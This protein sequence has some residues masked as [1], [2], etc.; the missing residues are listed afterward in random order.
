MNENGKCSGADSADSAPVRRGFYVYALLDPLKGG[1]PF[2]I[3]KGRGLRYSDHYTTAYVGQ[4]SHKAYTIRRYRSLGL[5]DAHVFLATNLSE[6]EAFA[7]EIEEIAR[8][9]LRSDGGQLVNIALGGI[10]RRQPNTPRH[11]AAISRGSKGRVVSAETRAKLSA[12][13]KGRVPGPEHLAKISAALNGRPHTPEHIKAAAAARRGK[14]RILTEVER[15]RRRTPAAREA[16]AAANR[17][18][19]C[20]AEMRAKMR[21]AKLGKTLTLEHRAKISSALRGYHAVKRRCL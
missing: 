13:M 12:R 15:A 2:Y 5:N 20:S 19:V 1:R 3:G 21:A 7:R 10:G 14:K 16:S 18:R 9:G 6:E 4:R 17:G 11:R 8:L